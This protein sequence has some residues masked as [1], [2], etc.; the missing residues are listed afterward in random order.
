MASSPL[1]R[2]RGYARDRGWDRLRLLSSAGT[3]YNR[4][5]L[6]ETADGEQRSVLNVFTRSG[7]E[8]R[9]FYATEKGPTGPGQDDRHVDLLWPLWNVLDLTPLRAAADLAARLLTTRPDPRREPGG[10]A[11][12]WPQAQP[13]PHPGLDGGPG[14]LGPGAARGRR[15]RREWGTWSSP[16]TAAGPHAGR[17]GPRMTWSS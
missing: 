6:A 15:P 8:I 1:E 5:Y 4:D 2:V 3:S 17:T 10:T 12:G 7:G 14:A 11:L 9:H 16:G 13:G